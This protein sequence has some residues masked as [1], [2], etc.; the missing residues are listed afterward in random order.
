MLPRRGIRGCWVISRSIDFKFIHCSD[1]HLDSPFQVHTT[2]GNEVSTVLH[3]AAVDS[4]TA[5]CD[6]AID[7][8][9]D[10]IVV[11][12]DV[13]DGIERGIRAQLRLLREI[14]K[15]SA[16]GIDV[17][18]AFGNHDPLGQGGEMAIKWPLNLH[19]FP[20]EP[21][22]FSLEKEGDLYGRITGISYQTK[23]EQR[24]LAQLFPNVAGSGLFEIAVLHGNIGGN[25]E[26]DNYSPATLEDLVSKGYDYWAL[27][28]IHKRMVLSESPFVIYPGNLQGLHMKPSERGP[29]GA[30][31]VSVGSEVKHRFTPFARVVFEQIE[32]DVTGVESV[33]S[34]LAECEERAIALVANSGAGSLIVRVHLVGIADEELQRA[35]EDIESVAQTLA[36]EL[37]LNNSR[38]LL[39]GMSSSVVPSRTLDDLAGLSDVIG[40]LVIEIGKWHQSESMLDQ[41]VIEDPS[42]KNIISKL[43]RVG[44]AQ[45]LK[46]DHDD[47]EAAS[48]VLTSLFAKEE[49]S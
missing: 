25:T 19:I 49:L 13:Y 10:F 14:S 46:F 17:Y 15:L 23:H 3:D 26:H 28:H 2:A 30:E 4:F 38:V 42:K 35:I 9:V 21:F 18:M 27:G 40:E 5:L 36:E 44:L 32:V 48:L 47:L 12:G 20:T 24:N 43:S 6:F 34:L 1:L 16:S 22:T 29:K 11:S 45:A 37:Q 31:F 33:D 8:G 7:E 41:M 39:E